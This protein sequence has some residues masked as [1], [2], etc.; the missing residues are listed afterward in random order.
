MQEFRLGKKQANLIGDTLRG[1]PSIDVT[2]DCPMAK[3]D[4]IRQ[5]GG[6]SYL[7]TLEKSGDTNRRRPAVINKIIGREA[8]KANYIKGMALGDTKSFVEAVTNACSSIEEPI[9]FRVVYGA[10]KQASIR[11]LS[12]TLPAMHAMQRIAEFTPVPTY[13]QVVFANGISSHLNDLDYDTVESE[14]HIIRRGVE[15]EARQLGLDQQIGFY[16]DSLISLDKVDYAAKGFEDGAPTELV[17]ALRD[18]GFNNNTSSQYAA[19]H[20]LVHDSPDT[21]LNFLGGT[22]VP[23]R[24]GMIDFGGV[25]EKYFKAAR[26]VLAEVFS[27]DISGPQVY[28][29]HVVPPYYMARGGDLALKDFLDGSDIGQD[30]G[31]AAH[32]DINYLSKSI[33][34]NTLREEVKHG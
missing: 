11:S 3:E 29:K 25:Q 2:T 10:T 31:S 7:D 27:V 23:E 4:V 8:R 14:A 16:D 34:L 20:H 13:L 9:T 15:E 21:K 19:A 18:K 12:Y 33:D 1:V 24:T 22:K 6:L 30:F 32:H 5:I 26:R 17:H 28:T